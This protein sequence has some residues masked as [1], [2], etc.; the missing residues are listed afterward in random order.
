MRLNGWQRIGVVLS[1]IWAV[2]AAEYERDRQIE[3]GNEL[4]EFRYRLCME[5]KSANANSCS[6]KLGKDLKKAVEPFWGN[7]AFYSL[8]PVV[9]GWVV[10]YLIII[11]VRWVK[12]G[13]KPVSK[14]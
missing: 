4:A 7:I 11:I 5:T 8:A 1:I 3:Q 6:E 14:K 9:A 2:G 13:F 12:T 10:I